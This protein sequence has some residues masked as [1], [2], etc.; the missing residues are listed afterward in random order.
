[1]LG[2]LNMRFLSKYAIKFNFPLDLNCGLLW[3]NV[4]NSYILHE[5]IFIFKIGEEQF[6]LY[7]DFGVLNHL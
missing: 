3:R 6:K 4:L 5:G 1:M 7:E 2:H